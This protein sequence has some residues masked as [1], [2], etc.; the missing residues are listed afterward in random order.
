MIKSRR[1]R[2]T[3]HITGMRRKTNAY[4]ILVKKPEGNRTLRRPRRRR[5]VNNKM[6]LRKIKWGGMDW[7]DL[8]QDG[9]QW[10]VLVNTVMNLRVP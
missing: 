10:R 9:N 2:W 6:D 3:G 4:K 7:T 5:V 1:I 8:T